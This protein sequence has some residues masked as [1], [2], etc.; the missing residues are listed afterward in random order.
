M[1]NW[2]NLPPWTSQYS[3]ANRVD[4]MDC[5]AESFINIFYM[6]TGF[7]SSPRALAKIAHTTPDGNS[8]SNILDAVKSVG[9]IP[10]YLW[11]SPH[12]FQ[13]SEY[14]SDIPTVVLEQSVG[15]KATK[16][17]PDLNISP[18]WTILRFPN[19][20]QH[21]VCQINETEYFDSEQG[22]PVKKLTYGGAVVISQSSLIFKPMTNV[23]LVK[24]GNEWGFYLPA[25]NEQAM[26]DK[27]LN[28]NYPLPT[29]NNGQNV[30]WPQ[31][32]PD[33]TL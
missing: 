3:V 1:K 13:W 25:T 22:S 11:P 24:K 5:L 19:G 17:A 33:I 8:E 15:V 18:L 27:A 16:V 21:G 2:T 30:D 10:Y 26:I 7:D 23:Q 32:K 31:V 29:I 6:V 9:L 14:Y 4:V 28:L 20:A 12:D